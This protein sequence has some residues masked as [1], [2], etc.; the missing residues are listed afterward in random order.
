MLERFKQRKW[1]YVLVAVMALGTLSV[2]P[3]G[4]HFTENTKHLAIHTWQDFIKA[5][6]YTRKQSNNRFV[7]N[8]EANSV[9]G[10]MILDGTISGADIG[11]N[12]IEGVDVFERSLKVPHAYGNVEDTVG[13]DPSSPDNFGIIAVNDGPSHAAGV[14]CFD[15]TIGVPDLILATVDESTPGDLTYLKQTPGETLLCDSGDDAL[16][17]ATDG[18]GNLKDNVEFSVAF[19]SFA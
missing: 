15:L 1:V 12:E 18:A 14:F 17:L 8:G 7:N 5:R 6:V 2:T 9:T 13:G 4:A 11:T 10:G 19:F 3:A 16:I